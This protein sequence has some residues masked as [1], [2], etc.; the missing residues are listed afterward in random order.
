[1]SEA[2]LRMAVVSADPGFRATVADM[3]HLHGEMAS[4]VLDLPMAA[5]ALNAE[6]ID[7]VQTEGADVVLVDLSGDPSGAMRMV[8]LL[9][10]NAPGRTLIG[11]GP[12]LSPELLLEGM[13][14]GIGEYL[15]APVDTHDLADA[16][17][18]AG[19]RLGRGGGY[20]KAG[21]GR[22]VTFMGAKGGT[23]VTTA[24]VNAGICLHRDE[25][26]T[27]LL[28]LNLEGGNLAVAMGLK[29]RYSIMDLLEN[30][31]RVD[32]SLLSSLVVKHESGVDVLASPLL[33]ESVSAVSADQARA[34]LRLLRR[35]YDL[36]VID[37][38]RPYSEY[39]RAAVDSSDILFLLLVPDVLAIHGAKRL[40]PLV[41]RAVESRAGRV[42]VV[43][44]RAGSDDEIQKQDVREA[45]DVRNV[46]VLRSDDAAMLSAVNLGKPLATLNGRRSRY[47]KDLRALCSLVD[48]KLETEEVGGIRRFL[49]SLS[50]E[51]GKKR[52]KA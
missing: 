30:F 38:A 9:G 19:R 13:K 16:L 46:R 1:M 35:H 5:S 45:L 51:R 49:E 3:L 24:A 2:T 22:V 21:V 42:E 43:L 23:G 37:L 14:A 15:P 7:R 17:R 25:Q 8:R 27:L 31:H 12:A 33:P 4:V 52:V 47:T 36:I 50:G 20:A 26:R 6:S 32:E 10:D 28:D 18:R 29:P 40:L 39:G 34:A 44:S 41:S 11:T 48:A